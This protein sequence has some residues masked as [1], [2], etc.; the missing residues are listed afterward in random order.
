MHRQVVPAAGGTYTEGIVGSPRLINPLYASANEADAGLANLIYSGLFRWDPK[1]GLIP[2]LAESL[3]V[4]E[5][6]K[7]FTIMLR[8]SAVW[9]HGNPVRAHDVVFTVHCLQN[10]AYHSPLASRFKDVVVTEQDERTV[11]F[12]LPESAPSFPSLL[13]IGLLPSDLWESISPQNISLASLELEPVGSGP[14]RFERMQLDKSG[15]VKT[16][17]LVRN[18]TFYGPSP[19]VDRLT[20]KFYT[21]IFQAVLALENRQIGGVGGIS[22]S[23]LAT[24]TKR[25]GLQIFQPV[26]PAVTALFFNQETQPLL[27]DLRVRKAIALALDR[28]KISERGGGRAAAGLFPNDFPEFPPS[29]PVPTRD[30]TAANQLLDETDYKK[31][32]NGSPRKKTNGSSSV[33]LALTLSVIDQ[34]EY[35]QS[36]QEIVA[37]LGE[38]GVHLTLKIIPAGSFYAETVKPRS[39][40]L[41]LASVRFGPD[42]DPSPFWHS[43]KIADPGLNLALY[44]NRKTDTLLEENRKNV[45]PTKRLEALVAFQQAVQED[46]PAVILSQLR[47]TYVLSDA[48]HISPPGRLLSPSD[49]FGAISSWYVKTKTIFN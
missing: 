44:G 47:Y 11:Q 45:D 32:E 3:S 30:V 6:G 21:D 35:I 24:L 43:S 34:P 14:Y 37:Q 10:P 22:P 5:D 23:L 4:S 40:E 15:N 42:L 26:F 31:T 36:A 18:D 12:V 29:V 17:T 38:I 25:R 16:Y 2:D 20:F 9:H 27:K 8:P 7:T 13:T 1:D 39:Y 41:L 49:R 48:V 19:L 33:E 28:E 46:V